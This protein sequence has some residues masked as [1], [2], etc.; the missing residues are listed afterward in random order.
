MSGWWILTIVSGALLIIGIVM[1]VLGLYADYGDFWF[2]LGAIMICIFGVC[3]LIFCL[4]A[5]INPLG[6]KREYEVFI[7]QRA[8]IEEVIDDT[9]DIANAGINNVIIETNKWLAEAKASKKTY[10]IFSRY[11]GLSIEDI[12]PIKISTEGGT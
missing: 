3:T 6:A 4:V 5:I 12:E 2:H 11:Y 8:I 9:D 7:E 1:V 10:G